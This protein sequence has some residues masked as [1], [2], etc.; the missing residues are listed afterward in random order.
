MS[1]RYGG[2]VLSIMIV[3]V[4]GLSLA[5]APIAADDKPRRGGILLWWNYADP[6]RLDIHTESGLTV[7]QAIAG[8]YSGLVQWGPEEPMKVSP[9]LAERW[10]VSD[11]GTTYTFHLR[12]GVKWHDG[13]PFTS[14]DALYSLK[15]LIDPDVRS[16]RCGSLL[17]PL[18]ASVEAPDDFTIV[19]QSK[20]PTP[21]L[22]PSMA[23]AWCK[24]LPKHILERDGDLTRASSQIG[25]GPFKLKKYVRGSIIE[26]ERNPDYFIKE[27]PYMDGVKQYILKGR[28]TQVA[29][30]KSG[31]TNF[32]PG[33]PLKRTH[34]AEIKQARPD[35]V[36]SEVPSGAVFQLFMNTKKPPFDNPDMRRAVHLAIDRQ[37]IINKGS[38]GLGIPCVILDP[39]LF[40]D[41][42]LP[43]EEVNQMPGCRQPKDQDIAEAK[44]LV[45]K[46][47]PNGLDVVVSIRNLPFYLD[48]GALVVPM[49]T[50]IGIRASLKT[51]ESAAGFA[52]WARGDFTI[53][54]SQ[55]TLMTVMEPSAPFTLIFTTNSPRNYGRLPLPEMDELYQKGLRELDTEKR[56][57]IY[58]QYQRQ[59]LRGDTAAVTY[60][61]GRAPLFVSKKMHNWSR[62]P[63]G[64]DNTSFTNVWLEK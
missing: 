36:Y 23:S 51:W 7:S 35:M 5:A 24:I 27:W 1:T 43:L 42:A 60:G 16:P 44:R 31:R 54:G 38:D 46:H 17:R 10:D 50:K 53:I 57:A 63:T 8:L 40:G 56:K 28:P 61:W 26:W 11:D 13:K 21:I 64:Y 33:F 58:R 14:A 59:I 30:L 29:A 55:A 62:G 19:V 52:A 34:I 49:L 2:F 47:Y 18:V 4:L 37:T 9:D 39:A 25:T 32:W 15:R 45:A 3:L 22:L 20:F 41:Y 48:H 12:R 6:A